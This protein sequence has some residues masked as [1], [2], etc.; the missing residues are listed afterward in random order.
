MP[1]W[2]RLHRVLR[3]PQ[4]RRPRFSSWRSPFHVAW[5][6]DMFP[7]RREISEAVS[8]LVL[9]SGSSSNGEAT[10]LPRALRRFDPQ[11][12]KV[13]PPTGVADHARASAHQ[14]DGLMAHGMRS[15]CKLKATRAFNRL[16][17]DSAR[18]RV[19]SMTIFIFR[20]IS[21][22]F[23]VANCLENLRSQKPA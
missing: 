5:P 10:R 3:E 23:P 2:L 8:S 7:I 1:L 11:W 12:E 22:V 19:L 17:I 9:Q 13:P 6:T 4:L 15:A 14:S 16:W 20:N 18:Q 21:I